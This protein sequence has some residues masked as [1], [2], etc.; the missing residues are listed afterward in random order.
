MVLSNSGIHPHI[1]NH[2]SLS[3]KSNNV[4]KKT[5]F[6]DLSIRIIRNSAPLATAL[7]LLPKKVLPIHRPRVAGACLTGQLWIA[8]EGFG[9]LWIEVRGHLVTK[10]NSIRYL[11]FFFPI[12]A[13]PQKGRQKLVEKVCLSSRCVWA[14]DI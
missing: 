11:L 8:T 10:V 3:H 2:K 12:L 7:L 9:L 13:P 6:V 4:I 5:Y 14:I 1:S